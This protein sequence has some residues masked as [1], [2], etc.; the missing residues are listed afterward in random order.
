MRLDTNQHIS[1]DTETEQS[2]DGEAQ[3]RVARLL[4]MINQMGADALGKLQP[5]EVLNKVITSTWSVMPGLRHLSILL[6]EGEDLVFSAVIGE[7]GQLLRGQRLPLDTPILHQ[8]MA[9]SKTV[10]IR[11]IFTYPIGSGSAVS[12]MQFQSQTV[13]AAPLKMQEDIIGVMMARCGITQDVG[14]DDLFIFNEA[15]SWAAA[16]ISAARLHQ[17]MLRQLSESQAVF[18]IGQALTGTL[19]LDEVFNLIVEFAKELITAVDGA[20]IH[21]LDS[22]HQVLVA[23]AAA[24]H[25]GTRKPTSVI[26]VG[27]GI[28]GQVLAEG[29]L[30]NVAD[31]NNDPRGLPSQNP[32]LHS[33]MVAPISIGSELV[34][35]ISVQS[36]QVSAFN[37]ADEI[38]LQTLGSEAGLAI[39]NARLYQQEH[40]QRILAEALEKAA[41]ALN[42]NLDLELVLDNILAQVAQV[43]PC[44]N[45]NV[46]LI[47]GQQVQVVREWDQD[48]SNPIRSRLVSIE[49]PLNL[50]TLQKMISTGQPLLIPDTRLEPL[51]DPIEGSEWIRSYIGVPLNTGD[52]TLGFLN[53]DSD[54][55][56]SFD[57]SLLPVMQSFAAHAAIAIQ[58]ARL[59]QDLQNSLMQEKTLRLQLTRADRLATMGMITASIN[60]PIQAVLGCLELAQMDALEPDKQAEYLSMA[61]QEMLRLA[62]ITKRVLNYQR[63]PQQ[64]AAEPMS[65]IPVVEDVLALAKKKIQHAKVSITTEWEPELPLVNGSPNELK[66]VFLNLVLNAVDAMTGGGKLTVSARTSS[67]DGKW[68]QVLIS[69]TGEGMSP[70]VQAR[71]YEPFFSTKEAGTG[72]GLWVSRDIIAAHAGKL[73]CESTLGVGTTFTVW[74]PY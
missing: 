28:A 68:V 27:E 60:N 62:G 43:V 73:T 56:N 6:R 49:L 21:R 26:K 25:T 10:C 16:S 23:V 45:F 8:V 70:E 51:W 48:K 34:G 42:R 22:A 20:V 13:M 69:D 54:Q 63:L 71:L 59:V 39:K 52:L 41:V 46:M 61:R 32:Y 24:G 50:P 11:D 14:E 37:E 64:N 55:P 40:H 17:D 31:L 9:E 38:L 12:P 44:Q 58:N 36:P 5:D 33:L 4:T 35:T 66:Q 29:Q 57:E 47:Q 19:E 72:L 30:I 53:A 3:D 18:H 1:T 7:T 65:M 15:A 2:T 67:Q 74:L